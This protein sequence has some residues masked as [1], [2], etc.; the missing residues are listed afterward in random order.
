LPQPTR[1]KKFPEGPAPLAQLNK[2]NDREYML[3]LWHGPTAAFKDVALQLL[4]HLMTQAVAKT[5][6]KLKSAF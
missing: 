2:Y 6:G 1:K 5:G 3:E 4:P